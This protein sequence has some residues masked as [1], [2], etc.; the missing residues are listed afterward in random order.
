MDSY[1]LAGNMHAQLG[2]QSKAIDAFNKGL[3]SVSTSKEPYAVVD[4]RRLGAMH[5]KSTRIDMVSRVLGN[6][7]EIKRS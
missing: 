3:S 4:M 6:F 7:G 5:P 1:L 2:Y